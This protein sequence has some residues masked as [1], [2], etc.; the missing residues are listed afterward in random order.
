MSIKAL[1]KLSLYPM[2]LAPDSDC[3]HLKNNLQITRR[4]VERASKYCNIK[5]IEVFD[6]PYDPSDYFKDN[7][8]GELY[9]V[10][11]FLKESK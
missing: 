6:Y 11:E 7:R 9:S 10:K 3:V 1:K 5:A 2:I 8:R 4:M